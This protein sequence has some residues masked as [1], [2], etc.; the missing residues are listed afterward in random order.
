MK[1]LYF[2]LII[3]LISNF[4][5]GQNFKLSKQKENTRNGK[6]IYYVIKDQPSIKHGNYIIKA[7]S[8]NEV[9]LEGEYNQGRRVGKWTEKYYGKFYNGALKNTGNYENDLKVGKWFYFDHTGDTVQ[10]YDHSK[11]ELI[12]P[13]NNDQSLYIGGLSALNYELSQKIPFPKELNTPGTNKLNI[14]TKVEIKINPDNKIES[15]SF[16]DPI[17]YGTEEVIEKWLK[18]DSHQ[19]VYSN[20]RELIIVP[21]KMTMHF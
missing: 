7:W 11:N 15:I 19:W 6:A 16:S 5:L 14:D 13:H 21:I 9:L 2:T 17:G 1:T 10:I 20:K 3:T 8:G 12:F 4:A 18:N